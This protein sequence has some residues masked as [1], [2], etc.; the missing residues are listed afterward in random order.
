MPPEMAMLGL[1]HAEIFDLKKQ[2][3]AIKEE[4]EITTKLVAER[5]RLLKAIP[6]CEVHGTECVPHAIE[7]VEKVKTLGRVI[8][9]SLVKPTERSTT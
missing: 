6:P 3:S 4:L 9:D 1:Q 5:T 2:L 8:L 7:W